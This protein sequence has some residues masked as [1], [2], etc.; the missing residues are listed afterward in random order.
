MADPMAGVVLDFTPTVHDRVLM[1]ALAFVAAMVWTDS[2]L[3]DLRQVIAEV[4]PRVSRHPAM[5]PAGRA[6]GRLTAPG[7]DTIDWYR[8]KLDIQMVVQDW[9]WRMAM[10]G[11]ATSRDAAGSAA[12]GKGPAGAF[13]A[14]DGRSPAE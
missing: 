14:D 1:H 10:H 6:A 9:S 4:L 2:R 12:P 8:L 5:G 11:V 7:R 3:G 13:S